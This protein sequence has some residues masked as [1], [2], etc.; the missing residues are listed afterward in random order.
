[1]VAAVAEQRSAWSRADVVQAI[2]DLQQPASQLSG[3][4]W[5]AAVEEVKRPGIRGGSDP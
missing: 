4:G 1:V 2:C 5:A 3:E